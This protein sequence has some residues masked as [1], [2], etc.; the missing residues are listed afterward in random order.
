[1]LLEVRFGKSV[2][3][4]LFDLAEIENFQCLC[5]FD[6]LFNVSLSKSR[7]DCVYDFVGLVPYL[8]NILFGI[9]LLMTLNDFCRFILDLFLDD[10]W[11][12]IIPNHQSLVNSVANHW[13]DT[14]TIWSNFLIL[15]LLFLFFISVWLL[16][17]IYQNRIEK[18]LFKLIELCNIWWQLH[19]G[20]Y[21]VLAHHTGHN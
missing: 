17:H 3:L 21:P 20:W 4:L 8:S 15:L 11:A 6:I 5:N 14:S 2:S 1:M 18:V 10:F 9:F 16:N 7:V 19:G 12:I 13:L